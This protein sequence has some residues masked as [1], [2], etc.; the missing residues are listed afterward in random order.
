MTMASNKKIFI[1]FLINVII[2]SVY[3]QCPDISADLSECLS[4]GGNVKINDENGCSVVNC[5][6][7]ATKRTIT[8]FSIKTVASSKSDC[9]TVFPYVPHRY[10]CQKVGG[11]YTSYTS[12]GCPTP[13]CIIPSVISIDTL[14]TIKNCPMEEDDDILSPELCSKMNAKFTYITSDGCPRP[15]CVVE[16]N[17][18]EDIPVTY[19]PKH[20]QTLAPKIITTTIPESSIT[21]TTTRT[22]KTI[23]ISNTTTLPP[24][25]NQGCP[26]SSYI[27]E[28]V[29]QDQCYKRG[30]KLH[31]TVIDGCVTQI[32]NY[33]PTGS[34]TINAV[35]TTKTIPVI[36]TTIPVT[37][38]TISETLPPKNIQGCPQSSDINEVVYQDHCYKRGGKLHRT[39]IDGCTTQICKYI[40]TGSTTI[41]A[42]TT[43]KTIPVTTTTIPVTTTTISDD[44]LP[45]I[46]LGD[47]INSEDE[48]DGLEDELD[49]ESESET[50]IDDESCTTCME[51]MPMTI[52]TLPPKYAS[53]LP[54][55]YAST[56]P[57]K[58]ASTLPPKYAST[59]PPKVI[60]PTYPSKAIEGCPDLRS[61]NEI[62]YKDHCYKRNGRIQ[63]IVVDGCVTQTCRYLPTSTP[64][65]VP[66]TTKTLPTIINESCTEEN[67]NCR[68]PNDE[69]ETNVI[70]NDLEDDIDSNIENDLVDDVD[71]NIENDL[72]DDVDS[73][74]EEQT[75]LMS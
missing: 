75:T 53:T 51:G 11:E 24:K 59:L 54:P 13:T 4:S 44:E 21:T 33:L 43:T 72:V 26:E 37:T 62:A 58:Y 17:T 10:A 3:S 9:P 74:T 38:T 70:I 1:L 7:N 16:N 64:T 67:G 42:I 23:P 65:E 66:V 32:C 12:N 8:K 50:D 41:N 22:V 36:T 6:A 47:E 55:K 29:Y 19:P 61:I 14:P 68:I 35:T 40:P 2:T 63:T 57:P 20:Y 30:G 31:R 60:Y 25:N 49:S 39:V 45:T 5:I 27:N 69:T 34:T 71:S 56:L 73:D 28:V 52:D 46:D 48:T 15:T 18:V